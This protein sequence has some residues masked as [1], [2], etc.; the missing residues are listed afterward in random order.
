VLRANQHNPAA[1]FP[2]FMARVQ[3]ANPITWIDA[4]D[5]PLFIEHGTA[6]RVV[7][8]RQSTRL[9]DAALAAG[10]VVEYHQAD[11]VAHVAPAEA[12]NAL[13]RQFLLTHLQAQPLFVDG[14]E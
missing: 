10:L 11:G 7:P 5:P 2:F 3:D 1:P 8:I 14:F 9:L 4:G 6:D 12:I 13:A